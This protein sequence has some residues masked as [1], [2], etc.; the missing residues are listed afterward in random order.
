MIK[1]ELEKQIRRSSWYSNMQ[2]KLEELA[3]PSVS[4]NAPVAIEEHH[5]VIMV[6]ASPLMSI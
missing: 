1:A 4:D 3:D 6:K 5:H 2:S